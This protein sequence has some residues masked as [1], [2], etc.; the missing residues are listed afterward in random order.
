MKSHLYFAETLIEH[1]LI[2][3]GS[4][5]RV[6]QV[7]VIRHSHLEQRAFGCDLVRHGTLEFVNR[8]ADV[9]PSCSMQDDDIRLRALEFHMIQQRSFRIRDMRDFIHR[10]PQFVGC[11]AAV[12]VKL[13]AAH[14]DDVSKRAAA[15]QHQQ[16]ATHAWVAACELR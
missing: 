14:A 11:L 12:D 9:A 2:A 8:P 3:I 4:L 5:H 15:Q 10:N 6:Q 13:T 16:Q 1:F 7:H